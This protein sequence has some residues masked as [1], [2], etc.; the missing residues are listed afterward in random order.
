MARR[1]GGVRRIGNARGKASG[2][3]VVKLIANLAWY[4]GVLALGDFIKE[5]RA[6]GVNPMGGKNTTG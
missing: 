5:A 6:Y 4:P 2:L 1:A 3:L